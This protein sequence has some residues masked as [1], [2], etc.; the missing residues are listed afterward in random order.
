MQ[1]N[2][3]KISQNNKS[4]RSKIRKSGIA[5]NFIFRNCYR[6]MIVGLSASLVQP[7]FSLIQ[8]CFSLNSAL[9]QRDVSFISGSSRHIENFKN[10][11]RFFK[12]L[13]IIAKFFAK[14]NRGGEIPRFTGKSP[15]RG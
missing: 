8:P 15:P 11:V 2:K 6:N 9:N 5:Y 4:G 1:N 7:C 3:Y 10:K 13:M 14:R 12:R